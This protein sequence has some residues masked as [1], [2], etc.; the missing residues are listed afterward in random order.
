M[1]EAHL[2]RLMSDPIAAEDA[3]ARRSRVSGIDRM[4]QIMDQLRD[5]GRPAT[6][7]WPS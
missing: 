2:A 7:T 3:P 4:L 1:S 6:A 5:T